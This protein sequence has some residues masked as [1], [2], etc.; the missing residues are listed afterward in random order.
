L[1][2]RFTSRP[3]RET[4]LVTG[5][6]KYAYLEQRFE[7]D[8]VLRARAFVKGLFVDANGRVPSATVAAALGY[9]SRQS[10]AAHLRARA[11]T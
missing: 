4:R 7:A 1:T 8:G 9:A 5:D 11:L 2:R 6:D 3:L 10:Q